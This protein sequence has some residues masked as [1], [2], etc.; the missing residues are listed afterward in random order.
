MSTQ[1]DDELV[2]PHF[3]DRLWVE[4][5]RLHPD[6][7]ERAAAITDGPD[8]RRRLLTAV[9][10]AVAAGVAVGGAA[11]LASGG[12]GPSTSI[13]PP[14]QPAPSTAPA[15]TDPAQPGVD[16]PPGPWITSD[17][18]TGIP[19]TPPTTV[20]HPR[21]RPDAVVFVEQRNAGGHVDHRWVDEATGRSRDLQLDAD[22]SP[23]HDSGWLDVEETPA[24]L[25]FRIRAVDYCFA[26]YIETDWTPPARPN[27]G[28]PDWHEDVRDDVDRGVLVPDGTEVV[29]GRELLR[30][31]APDYEGVTWA[32]PNTYAPVKVH[33]YVGSDAEYTQTYQYLPRTPE[34]LALLEP[35][36]PPGFTRVDQLRSDGESRA[37]GCW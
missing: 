15:T 23:V 12:D 31:R 2:L 16:A 5:A 1:L 22:G 28:T 20:E 27:N 36:V 25:S 37:A 7:D 14:A 4:L 29:D 8:R 35:V 26:E 17:A 9:A 11:L 19:P 3:E 33:N 6:P 30:Y 18:V 13:A 32:D 24:G 34:N 10:A 21:T